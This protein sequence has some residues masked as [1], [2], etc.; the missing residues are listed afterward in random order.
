MNHFKDEQIEND[1]DEGGNAAA[2]SSSVLVISRDAKSVRAFWIHAH[3]LMGNVEWH[4]Y[5]IA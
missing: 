5:L 1:D 4:W 2:S 3:C